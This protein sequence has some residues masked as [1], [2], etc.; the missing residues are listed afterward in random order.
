MKSVNYDL[1]V[2]DS[3]YKQFTA[4]KNSVLTASI[5]LVTSEN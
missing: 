5:R 4:R 1:L 3:D 2:A